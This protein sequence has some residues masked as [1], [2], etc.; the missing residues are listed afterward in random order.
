MGQ[1]CQS[2]MPRNNQ[3]HGAQ[4]LRSCQDSYSRSIPPHPVSLR[5]IL[6]LFSYPCLGLPSG[7]F[8]SGFLTK[9]LYG[10]SFAHACYMPCPSN[11]LWLAHSSYIWWRIQVAKLLIMTFFPTSCYFNPLRSTYILLS[12]LFSNT[13]SLGFSFNVRD[14][15][16]HP[17][18]TTGK[19]IVFYILIFMFLDSRQE[20]SITRILSALNFLL[21]QVLI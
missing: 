3:L 12:T 6:I 18:R 20:A 17:Y 1:F 10:I 11:P 2:F 9:A 15:V 21:N 13:L 16:S 8:L 14:Q 7:F 5:S 4:S 19:I